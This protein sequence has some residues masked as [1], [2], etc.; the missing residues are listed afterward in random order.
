MLDEKYKYTNQ[1]LMNNKYK[2]CETRDTETHNQIV[3][4]QC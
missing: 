2:N 1:S 4:N 3:Q